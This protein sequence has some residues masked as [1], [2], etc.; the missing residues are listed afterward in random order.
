MCYYDFHELTALTDVKLYSIHF[1][2]NI[3]DPEISQY[4]D[5]NKFHC[6][7]TDDETHKIVH[8][9]Q[10]LTA[11]T[12]KRQPFSN[13]IIQN[14]ISEIVIFMI[15]KSSLTNMHTNPYQSIRLSPI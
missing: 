8:R 10:E 4:L 5:F 14:I 12:E 2:Q 9:I 15:R 13:R 7:L 11:E 1:S 3:M 6:M